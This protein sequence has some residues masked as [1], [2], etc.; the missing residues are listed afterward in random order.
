[1]RRTRDRDR[2]HPRPPSHVYWPGERTATGPMHSRK[3]RVSALAEAAFWATGLLFVACSDP[4]HPVLPSVCLFDR[5]G[6]WLGIAFCPGCGLGRSV[7]WLARGDFG[8]SWQA[9][10]LALP[11][12]FVLA[13]HITRLL[14]T[15]V[16]GTAGSPLRGIARP[17]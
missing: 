15:A 14:R 13:A 10:P 16:R 8:A 4:L 6:D 9:H 5:M 7:G 3:T 12:V 17:A 1:M 11:A 2:T